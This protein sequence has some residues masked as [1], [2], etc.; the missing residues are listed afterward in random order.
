MDSHQGGTLTPSVAARCTS[1]LRP[2]EQNNDSGYAKVTI[3]QEA[4]DK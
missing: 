2:L 4:H 1:E 3:T